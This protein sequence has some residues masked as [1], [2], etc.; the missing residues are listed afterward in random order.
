[1]KTT[2]RCALLTA[3]ASLSV[4]SPSF[5]EPATT[6]AATERSQNSV[7]TFEQIFIRS[8]PSKPLSASSEQELSDLSSD[9]LLVEAGTA[10]L[11]QPKKEIKPLPVEGGPK[12][13]YSSSSF[14]LASLDEQSADGQL[15]R[16]LKFGLKSSCL[17][18]T[19]Q[20]DRI[21]PR[22]QLDLIAVVDRPASRKQHDEHYNFFFE[23]GQQLPL[24]LPVALHLQGRLE[25]PAQIRRAVR[26]A[27]GSAGL[28]ASKQL[29]ASQVSL[30]IVREFGRRSE[31]WVPLVGFTTALAGGCEL[32][33]LLPQHAKV[34]YR[35]QPE[36]SLFAVW[37]VLKDRQ[38]QETEGREKFAGIWQYKTQYTALGVEY[39]YHKLAK[40]VLEVG[41]AMHTR[42]TQIIGSKQIKHSI[43]RAC[44]ARVNLAVFF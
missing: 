40:A 20:E 23:A 44:F 26:R 10:K 36:A 31:R 13:G 22:E 34:S 16:H 15:K 37:R 30:G 8:A 33:L 14:T 9:E 27:Q 24:Q 42:G 39:S 11:D 19:Y 6:K 38:Y 4:G 29:Q 43:E 17:L 41:K 32:D 5:A 3:L 35:L 1:M 21:D 18:A 28:I 7:G 2:I 12:I 25:L